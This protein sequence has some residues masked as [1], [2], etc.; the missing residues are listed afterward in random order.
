RLEA[1][2]A[3]LDPKDRDGGAHT[4]RRGVDKL[5]HPPTGGVQGPAAPPGGGDHAEGVR[6]PLDLHSVDEEASRAG[7][8]RWARG[9]ATAPPPRR[10]TSA[11]R[12]S[13]PG[14]RP[15]W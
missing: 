3:D 12:S 5:L 8:S 9:G 13:R 7:H 4:V 6:P 1:R 14:T 10:G 2:L 11:T 15:S